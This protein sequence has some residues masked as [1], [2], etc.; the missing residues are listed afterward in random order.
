MWTIIELVVVAAVVLVA[1]TEFFLPLIMGKPLF[2]SFRKSTDPG[3]LEAQLKS[4]KRKVNDIK[5]VQHEVNRNFK[6]AE[7]LKNQA[8]DLLQ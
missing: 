8:D 6:S 5:E 2:G 4:A 7:T 3:S 1:I